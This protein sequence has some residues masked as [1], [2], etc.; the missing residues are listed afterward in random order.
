[1]PIVK[2]EF[3]LCKRCYACLRN[4]PIKAIRVKD[5]QVNVTESICITC[6]TCKNVC[7]QSAKLV[8][9]D[10]AGVKQLLLRKK[11]RI[12]LLAPSF[13]AA[14]EAPPEQVVGAMK[15]VGF[16]KVCEVAYG[17]ELAAREYSR[18]YANKRPAAPLITYPCPL[19][20]PS[21]TLLKNIIHA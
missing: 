15:A 3:E 6:G 20:L 7:S 17:A 12:A 5:G 11:M 13:V 14:F 8:R 1:M 10:V 21:S 2:T 18:L 19:V 9:N 16:D 4:C